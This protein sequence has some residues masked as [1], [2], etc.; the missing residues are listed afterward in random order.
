VRLRI[1]LAG[2]FLASYPEGGGVWMGF[3]QVLLG[4][5]ELG[6]DPFWLELL[7]SSG[8][9]GRD[10]ARVEAF[11]TRM[12]EYGLRDCCAV[13]VQRCGSAEQTLDG[14]DAYGVS[15]TR[16]EDVV[17]SADLLWNFAAA[18]RPP[19]LS[20]FRRRVL[21]DGDPGHLQVSALTADLAIT[22]HDAFLTV[23]S[24]LHDPDCDVP[25]LGVT[26]HRFLPF[27]HLPLWDVM[28]DPGPDAPITSVTQWT[29]E[30]LWLGDRVL[31]VSKR[32]AYL[33][34]LTLP[35]RAGRPFELA[36]NLSDT[37]DTGDR[38]LLVGHGWQLAHPHTVAA[39]P[40]AYQRYIAAS[41]AEFGC[42][43][44]IHRALRTG[45]FSDRSAA[46]LAS[47][48]PVV[49][50]DT[51]IGERLPTG[52]GL[53]L[54]RDLGQAV[55]CVSAIDADWPSHARAAREIAEEFLDGRQILLA[56]LEASA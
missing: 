24:K 36:V 43:K 14:G 3:L 26:W 32:D 33:P 56:M 48:R 19:L 37:D 13:L 18:I 15:R 28:P 29:W 30:E 12:H 38:E 52:K 27:V 50:E 1:V 8:N 54:F 41:R 55:E 40:A 2:G 25:T 51:G 16:L 21:V 23:G 53:L 20:L 22:E 35:R 11:F 47:G 46:Y 10:A 17:R 42:P 34:Y 4:L 5:R 31:S 6:H 49:F 7:P 39:S 45:W 9:A 44:P